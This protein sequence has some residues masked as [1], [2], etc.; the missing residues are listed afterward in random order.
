[1]EAPE[2]PKPTSEGKK[3]HDQPGIRGWLLSPLGISTFLAG[4]L[5]GFLLFGM[6]LPS[7]VGKSA[8]NASHPYQRPYPLPPQ[9]WA[10]RDEFYVFASGGP[11]GG[12]Y[13]YGLP[14]M[15]YLA[16]IPIFVPNE[17]W[18]WT[19][20]DPRVQTMLTNPWTGEV[21]THAETDEPVASRTGG[22]YDG[23]WIFVNDMLHPRVARVDLDT[24]RTGQVLWVPNL[25]GGVHG[26][27][28]GP[29]TR[30][31]VATFGHEAYPDLAII[32]HLDVK[33]DLI[34]GPYL[35]GFAGITV[36]EAGTMKNA[37]Q[38]WSPW[39]QDMVR[40]GW[41][42]S[43]GW[44]ITNVYNT[45]RALS[46]MKM[47]A[48]EQDYV[49]FWKLASIE[50]AVASGRFTTTSQAPDVP[51][52]AWRDVEVYAVPVP[53]NP[54]GVDI[55][56]TGRYV[57]VGSKA[58]TRAV[59]IDVEKVLQ[60]V[61][62]KRFHGEEF[63]IPLLDPQ[64]VYAATM[65]LG[66]GTT[67]VEF[68]DKG[69]AYFGSFVDSD[70][71]KVPLGPPYTERHH[72]QP[73]EVAEVIP[74]HYSVGHPLIPGGDSAHPWGR[75]LLAL[76]KFSKTTFL[77]HGPLHAESHELY[78]ITHN[79]ARLIDQMP[80]GPETHYAQALPVDLIAPHIRNVYEPPLEVEEPRV[81]YDY[82]N[83]EVRVYMD[84]VRSFYDPDW[85]TVPQGWRVVMHLTSKEEAMD[86]T[87]GLGIDGYDVAV[88]LDPGQVREVSFV[89]DKPGLH[90]Y[91]CLWYCSELHKEMRG[92]MIVIPQDQWSP[93]LE[94]QPGNV[95]KLGSGGVQ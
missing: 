63:G 55:S 95:A 74:A 61:Q 94:W 31:L 92:R 87:H 23:R 35:G 12:L 76:N 13:V 26:L 44:I 38:V 33:T 70:I 54:S 15:K 48:R 57:V 53:S 69:F 43:K 20:E 36:G 49:L 58:T 21:T 47:L 84:V 59:A 16:E 37:W 2:S 8:T 68:D 77:P 79:P 86:I 1:M 89:A 80:M 24:F 56:P 46:T 17:A 22:V 39:Q 11:Q 60:A 64:A 73:W 45:E 32:R 40:V 85:F 51:V 25:S 27:H 4:V 83:H 81:E 28:V 3:K 52:V 6:L 34:H 10:R 78:D 9:Y 72:M 91:Y 90:W 19:T 93:K 18:G 29:D 65:E 67:H 14:S 88:S 30:L 50:E 42:S 75:Y 66:L 41:G 82:E 71:K 5:V 7:L 62:D